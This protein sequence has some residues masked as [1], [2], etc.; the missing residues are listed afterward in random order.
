LYKFLASRSDS[1]VASAE[2]PAILPG[3][4]RAQSCRFPIPLIGKKFHTVTSQPVRGWSAR[5]DFRE[6][7][8]GVWSSVFSREPK[9]DS[10]QLLR[11][12]GLPHGTSELLFRE[13]IGLAKRKRRNLFSAEQKI[14]GQRGVT[15]RVCLAVVTQVCG[16]RNIVT[17]RLIQKYLYALDA[18]IPS[19]LKYE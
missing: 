16:K 15:A 18:R 13:N 1:W 8:R 17:K 19:R 6:D 10:R 9:A 7:C 2:R 12:R 5:L 14:N 3:S 4:R 11:N